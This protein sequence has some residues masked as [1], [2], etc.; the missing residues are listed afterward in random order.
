MLI[1]QIMIGLFASIGI[2]AILLDKRP[3]RPQRGTLACYRSANSPKR[4][5][6]SK[7]VDRAF[8]PLESEE[9]LDAAQKTKIFGS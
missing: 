9:Y 4:M 1:L 8:F 2:L 7:T 6:C 3:D 5:Y